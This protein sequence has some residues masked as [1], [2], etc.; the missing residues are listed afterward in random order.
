MA[1]VTALPKPGEIIEL[2]PLGKPDAKT[3]RLEVISM[4]PRTGLMEAKA[5]EANPDGE[6]THIRMVLARLQ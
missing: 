2:V 4:D 5:C 3:V 1:D 6:F